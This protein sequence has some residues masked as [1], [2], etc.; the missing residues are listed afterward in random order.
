MFLIMVLFLPAFLERALSV[1][2]VTPKGQILGQAAP[3]GNY[4]T[5]F[6][7]PYAQVD[8]NFPFGVSF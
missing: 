2:V 8:E 3:D 4:T 6:G 5:F 1:T 7:V